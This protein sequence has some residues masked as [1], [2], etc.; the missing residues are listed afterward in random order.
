MGDH[1]RLNPNPVRGMPRYSKH[2]ASYATRS[3]SYMNDSSN[4]TLHKSPDAKGN[5]PVWNTIRSASPQNVGIAYISPDK[6]AKARFS[7]NS[8]LDPQKNIANG[9]AKGQFFT[10][11]RSTSFAHEIKSKVKL[12]NPKNLNSLQARIDDLEVACLRRDSHIAALTQE[13][14]NMKI[15]YQKVDEHSRLKDEQINDLILKNMHLRKA[16]KAFD[17]LQKMVIDQEHASTTYYEQMCEEFQ[18]FVDS[19]IKVDK[20][21]RGIAYEIRSTVRNTTYKTGGGAMLHGMRLVCEQLKILLENERAR[22]SLRQYNRPREVAFTHNDECP[23]QEKPLESSNTPLQKAVRTP[24]NIR[25]EKRLNE[26]EVSEDDSAEKTVYMS[27]ITRDKDSELMKKIARYKLN[28]ITKELSA[29]TVQSRPAES[30]GKK[31]S[32]KR[33]NL[34][35]STYPIGGL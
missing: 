3:A 18:S 20:S 26:A 27:V 4:T 32:S 24:L 22:N 33:L 34:S 16:R 7:M 35:V 30:V 15:M 29:T 5:N 9:V 13:L 2:T 19:I 10:E 31:K 14:N 23:S 12:N 11:K 17:E 25:A 8:Y 21:L 28:K 6:D 1:K